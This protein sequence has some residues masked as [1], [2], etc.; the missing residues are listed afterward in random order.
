MNKLNW[1]RRLIAS[2]LRDSY[3]YEFMTDVF[4]ELIYSFVN[5]HNFLELK[6]EP[7]KFFTLKIIQ[8]WMIWAIFAK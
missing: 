2:C 4:S 8:V 6:V 3:A 1:K 7:I 5:S